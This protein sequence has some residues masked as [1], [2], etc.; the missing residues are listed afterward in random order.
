MRRFIREEVLK[1][2][3]GD[4]NFLLGTHLNKPVRIT[5]PSGR[6]REVT[7]KEVLFG[8]QPANARS[9]ADDFLDSLQQYYP[10]LQIAVPELEKASA[11]T[12][13]TENEIPLI[14]VVP[15]NFEK[16]TTIAAF[17][18][19]GDTYNL[20]I[21]NEPDH[22]VI[23]ISSNESLIGVPKSSSGRQDCPIA[24][25]PYYSTGDVDYYLRTDYYNSLN[26][27][28]II[29][30]PGTN[31]PGTPP[32]NCERDCKNTPEQL[33]RIKFKTIQDLRNIE[34]WPLGDIELNVSM[35]YGNKNGAGVITQAKKIARKD[36]R[37]CNGL[38]GPCDETIWYATNFSFTEYRTEYGS[39]I[40]VYLVEEDF[41]SI[42]T[43]YDY[44]NVSFNTQIDN[45]T[46]FHTVPIKLSVD[47]DYMGRAEINYCDKADP[48]GSLYTTPVVFFNW[49]HK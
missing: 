39:K 33:F 7:F 21:S 4:Y 9:S 11:E 24:G 44:F 46:Y 3:D 2:F 32:C 37:K 12:W 43:P 29:A 13:D 47:H 26:D 17:D 22:S 23:V 42:F 8:P 34:P 45:V 20:S 38:F 15:E 6:M 25:D 16:I 36:L 19:E 48:I 31:G 14:A 35:L 40:T 5:E 28:N 30:P 10:L 27:C 18:T 49:G 1:Q 41:G